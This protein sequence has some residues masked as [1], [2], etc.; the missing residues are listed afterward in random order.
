MQ[1]KEIEFEYG[2]TVN[3]GDYSN[4]RP[5]LRMVVLTEE[6]EDE[7]LALADLKQRVI[8]HVHDIADDELEASGQ[9]PKYGPL[10]KVARNEAR[11]CVAVAIEDF[12]WPDET[13]WRDQDLWRETYHPPLMRF[14]TAHEHAKMLAKR[15]GFAYVAGDLGLAPMPDP[16]P[17][18]EWHKKKVGIFFKR[19][20]IDTDLWN[21]LG[22]LEH[23]DR[24]YIDDL[25]TWRRGN[26]DISSERLA[27]MIR[28]NERPYMLEK[29]P[30]I[31]AY[32][33]E[34]DWVDEDL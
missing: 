15:H 16:G 13:T 34:D 24:Q 14:E 10:F 1:I 27:I 26:W 22:E 23:V 19:M 6:G 9:S 17:E 18:P 21:E 3:L 11:R 8:G 31:E 33:D 28:N 29:E 7:E 30:A 2:L 4:A 32:E 12:E 20:E 25:D 5:S